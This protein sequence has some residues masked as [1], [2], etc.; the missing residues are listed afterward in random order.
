MRDDGELAPSDQLLWHHA[1]CWATKDKTLLPGHTEITERCGAIPPAD[2]QRV[3]FGIRIAPDR[4]GR[5]AAS[6]IVIPGEPF[7]PPADPLVTATQ[8][9]L[10]HL[11][12]AVLT[13]LPLHS[14][15]LS[16]VRLLA[17]SG[18]P[19]NRCAVFGTERRTEDL[20]F[21][22][23]IW[24]DARHGYARRIDYHAR[25][26]SP[27]NGAIATAAAHGTR[28]YHLDHSDHWLLTHQRERLTFWAAAR[29]LPARGFA[30]RSATYAEYWQPVRAADT[31]PLPAP[32][33]P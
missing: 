20:E 1:C 26:L 21:D 3:H 29:D 12:T 6:R 31:V 9:L 10:D 30:E 19:Q 16:H 27:S 17:R 14:H 7:H 13:A 18:P 23:R 22:F 33:C 11:E 28:H 4:Q 32:S 2:E 25:S 5:P 8:A 24:I 15:D